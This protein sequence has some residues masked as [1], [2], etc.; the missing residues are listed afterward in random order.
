[1]SFGRRVGAFGAS[2][3]RGIDLDAI[4]RAAAEAAVKDDDRE[5]CVCSVSEACKVIPQRVKYRSLRVKNKT[6]PVKDANDVL[7]SVC[8][9]MLLYRYSQF[10]RV[11]SARSNSWLGFNC[12]GMV[13]SA[14]IANDVY[15]NLEGVGK[16]PLLRAS[17]V[18]DWMRWPKEDA[19]IFYFDLSAPVAPQDSCPNASAKSELQ[20]CANVAV[21]EKPE[22]IVEQSGNATNGPK[23][24]K[25][26]GVVAE[27]AEENAE[28][29]MRH[30]GSNGSGII[31]LEDSDK[32]SYATGRVPLSVCVEGKEYDLRQ[33]RDLFHLA[34]EVLWRKD[35]KRLLSVAGTMRKS[36][37]SSSGLGMRRTYFHEPSG[38]FFETN[39]S[40]IEILAFIRTLF[41]KSGVSPTSMVLTVADRETRRNT[42]GKQSNRQYVHK[43]AGDASD[44]KKDL[45]FYSALKETILR[46][47]PNG[48]LL[49]NSAVAILSQSLGR[50]VEDWEMSRLRQNMFERCDELWFFPEMIISC[51]GL[52]RMRARAKELLDGEGVFALEALYNE[53][54]A[55]IRN[56]PTSRDFK[57][58]FN[59]Y[60]AEFAGGSVRGHEGW[61]VCFR[62]DM[63]D[64]AGRGLIA[65]QIRMILEEAGD[66]VMV[67]DIAARRS[68][69]SH[70]VVTQAVE[71]WLD[72]VVL[73]KVDGVEYVK[74][75]KS[76]YLPDDFAE[77]VL[78]FV[79]ATETANGVVSIVLLESELDRC[80]GDGF[81]INYGLEDE[82]VFKQV[83]S[84]SFIG[85][86]HAWNKDMFTKNGKR[87][88]LN[89][90]EVFL[91]NHSDMFHEETFFKFA[92]ESRGMKN[93]GMLI[94]TFLRRHCIRMSKDWWV[95][96]DGFDRMFALNESQYSMIGEIL[97]EEVG[98][99]KF[100]SVISLGADVYERFPRLSYDGR[101]YLWN[102]YLL[103]SVAVLKVGNVRVVNDE[104]SPYTVTAMIVPYSEGDIDDVV[105]YVLKNFPVGYFVDV[106]SAF[107]YLKTNSIRLT[108]TEKLVSKIKKLI[109]VEA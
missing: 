82:D 16:T 96:V 77:N 56:L 42:E 91:K 67:D 3:T 63:S 70:G 7:L 11:I 9:A 45:E 5:V 86:D 14:K 26:S 60:I 98:N 92:L 94:A 83:I 101:D 85:D 88:G 108:K 79:K 78:A 57:K 81:R 69:L 23:Y 29:G 32:F 73:F 18:L 72:D 21:G 100:K 66:A 31:N 106:D 76:Y 51:E 8:K 90:I 103:A 28:R 36:D 24:L 95:S 59:R 30:D 80:Y 93:R 84:K 34:A 109:G 68:H 46:E 17:L 97:N 52:E 65:E 19:S 48:T 15:V 43:S 74:L 39:R 75:I 40:A 102:P 2:F 41:V 6:F 38:L 107:E 44:A 71:D 89:V 61:R 50:N 53:F 99:S 87:R 20:E 10:R 37:V 55:E 104:P 105:E 49:N 13:H 47:C 25:E 12:R 58:F 62:L 64:E 54:A 1:M 4:Y 35:A 33:W 22:T 27:R